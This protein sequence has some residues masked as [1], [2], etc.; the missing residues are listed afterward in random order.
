M[1]RKRRHF[2]NQFKFTVALEAVKGFKTV[3]QIAGEND[4]HPNQVSAWKRQLLADGP[5]V[6]DNGHS[7]TEQEQAVRETELYE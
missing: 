6:F 3:N 2:S 4:V 7:S 1:G 5:A